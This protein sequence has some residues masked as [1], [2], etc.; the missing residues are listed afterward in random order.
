MTNLFWSNHFHKC[1][2]RLLRHHRSTWN[3]QCKP[4]LKSRH[5]SG[6]QNHHKAM[7]YLPP[8]HMRNF[9]LHLLDWNNFGN[10]LVK[11]R[12]CTKPRTVFRSATCLP[13]R[14]WRSR[15]HSSIH[16]AILYRN[17]KS[18][19]QSEHFQ[20]YRTKTSWRYAKDS[21]S[22]YIGNPITL[23]KQNI[24]LLRFTLDIILSLGP[25][26]IHFY[27]LIVMSFVKDDEN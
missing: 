24:F 25:P 17:M 2:C 1:D 14:I 3:T 27:I 26:L 19:C 8:S 7:S 13:L 6:H 18:L 10:P 16:S 15:I 4:T 20:I 23:C 11:S 9:L 22:F 21:V 12:H 5:E